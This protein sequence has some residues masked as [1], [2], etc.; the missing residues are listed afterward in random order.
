MLFSQTIGMKHWIC[1]NCNHP[2]RTTITAKNSWRVQCRHANCQRVYIVGE[3]FY[4][5][6]PGFK[7]AP[8]DHVMPPELSEESWHSGQPVNRLV[9]A[10]E[11]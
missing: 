8:R 3:V 6:V 11:N 9:S 4:E 7:I 10:S 5:P 2:N 1:P